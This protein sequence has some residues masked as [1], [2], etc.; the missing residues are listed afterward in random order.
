MFFHGLCSSFFG[1]G[2]CLQV[3]VQLEFRPWFPSVIVCDLIDVRWNN[4]FPPQVAL[5][6]VFYPNTLNP[7]NDR[8]WYGGMLCFIRRIVKGFW[9][10]GLEKSLRIQS[11]ASYCQNFI[12]DISV[13]FEIIIT[14]ADPL[15][16]WENW[17][18]SPGAEESAEI[19]R[20]ESS[21]SVNLLESASSGSLH[22]SWGPRRT[23]L[24]SYDGGQ[25]WYDGRV[26][27]VVL[28]EFLQ[29]GQERPLV[30][31]QP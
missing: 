12:R 3:P 13:L 9:N 17:F 24:V 25:T 6:I 29:R 1:I 30:K 23:K 8:N 7:N 18:W 15:L 19:K 11:L 27:Q 20:R 28:V 21:L 10:P 31:I 5:V 26:P 2:S 4:P 16:C 22:R 14:K